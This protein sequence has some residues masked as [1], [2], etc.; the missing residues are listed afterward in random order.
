MGTDPCDTKYVAVSQILPNFHVSLTDVFSV[1]GSQTSYIA[2]VIQQHCI[3][4]I[5]R[6]LMTLSI[7]TKIY[8]WI[9]RMQQFQFTS[10][11]K[12]FLRNSF[13]N[14][15]IGYQ[16]LLLL[17]ETKNVGQ[18]RWNC[19]RFCQDGPCSFLWILWDHV[20]L[21]LQYNT[22]YLTGL[23]FQCGWVAE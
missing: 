16:I 10:Q 19:H 1:I 13:S 20:V 11:K 3:K 2:I 7:N 5:V 14:W 21:L 22:V 12:M 23:R 15:L 6:K 17:R 18:D 4:S 8:Y 9:K